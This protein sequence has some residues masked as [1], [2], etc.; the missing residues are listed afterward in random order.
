MLTTVWSIFARCISDMLF[1]SQISYLYWEVDA[2]YGY[3]YSRYLQWMALHS[4][5]ISCH[6]VGSW[7]NKWFLVLCFCNQWCHV[8][9]CHQYY[10]IELTNQQV[11]TINVWGD[12]CIFITWPV[13]NLQEKVVLI[14][15]QYK[16]RQTL[17]LNG[18]PHASPMACFH[19]H[20][21]HCFGWSFI[22]LSK[23]RYQ[24]WYWTIIWLCVKCI[25]YRSYSFDRC[26]AQGHK[27]LVS[28][29]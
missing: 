22:F 17:L 18:R 14:C 27:W 21:N 28:R 19:R 16:R 7:S 20:L 5:C 29:L 25:C 2:F 24:S 1:V 13:F 6:P 4:S 15:W 3:F 12:C 23:Q 10:P 9:F 11:E 26:K 8:S